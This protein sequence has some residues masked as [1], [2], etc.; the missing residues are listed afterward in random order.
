MEIVIK[1]ALQ[2]LIKLTRNVD[3]FFRC[4]KNANFLSFE[5]HLSSVVLLIMTVG[6]NFLIL[7]HF[8]FTVVLLV[9]AGRRLLLMN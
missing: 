4:C 5:T 6:R 1:D 7:V 3:D 2:I 9:L 8:T